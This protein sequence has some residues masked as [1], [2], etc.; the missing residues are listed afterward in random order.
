[1]AAL[2]DLLVATPALSSARAADALG[3]R[4]HG[5]RRLLDALEEKNL[6]HELT[7]RDAFR[8]YAPA[9]LAGFSAGV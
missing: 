5:A 4:S 3:I 6:V 7:G 2:I 1:M 9:S 8:L